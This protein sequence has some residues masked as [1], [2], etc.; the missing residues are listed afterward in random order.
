MLSCAHL[1]CCFSC[2]VLNCTETLFDARLTCDLT[3][4]SRWQCSKDKPCSKDKYAELQAGP[5]VQT[6]PGMVAA[7]N[8][9]IGA[10]KPHQLTTGQTQADVMLH[11]AATKPQSRPLT[12]AKACVD[13]EHV[14]LA[15]ASLNAT[16]W[17]R[18]VHNQKQVTI[19]TRSAA[20]AGCQNN[21]AQECLLAVG[22]RV[23]GRQT[24]GVVHTW[25]NL[26]NTPEHVHC[27]KNPVG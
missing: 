2:W 7:Q 1:Q 20:E 18:V 4:T 26:D 3:P 25:T 22:G 27:C 17:Q 21:Q 6:A 23:S 13:H 15:A 19:H 5:A 8:L 12:K 10:K 11:S 24:A 9:D 14:L 16:T